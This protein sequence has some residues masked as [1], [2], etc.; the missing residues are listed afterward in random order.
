MSFLFE[1]WKIQSSCDAFNINQI[2][3]SYCDADLK[4]KTVYLQHAVATHARNCQLCASWWSI[5]IAWALYFEVSIRLGF[6]RSRHAHQKPSSNITP[7][8]LRISDTNNTAFTTCSIRHKKTVAFPGYFNTLNWLYTLQTKIR[9]TALKERCQL[10]K[11]WI[12]ARDR[13]IFPFVSCRTKLT[14]ALKAR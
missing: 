9:Q 2:L 10:C 11:R 4:R 14:G 6:I 5:C 13:W 1:I 12:L 3:L 8:E 7:L